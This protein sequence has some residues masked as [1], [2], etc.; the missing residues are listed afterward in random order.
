MKFKR[1]LIGLMAVSLVIYLVYVARIYERVSGIFVVFSTPE[2]WLYSTVAFGLILAGHWVRA[3][4]AKLLLRPVKDSGIRTQFQALLIGYLFNMLLP[5]RLGEIVRAIVLGR[6]LKISSSFMF[7]LIVL[8]RAFDGIIL[9][10][11]G[12]ALLLYPGLLPDEIRD[13]VALFSGLLLLVAALLITLLVLLYRQDAKLLRFWH[14]FTSIFNNQLKNSL[15]FKLWSVIYG[16]HKVINRRAIALY[17]IRSAAM[18]AAYLAA[19]MILASYFF[20][21]Q[22][23]NNFLQAFI[24]FLGV[25]IPSGP[26]YL[27]SY[28]AVADPLFQILAP[29]EGATHWLVASWMLLAIPSSILGAALLLRHRTDYGKLLASKGKDSLHDKLARI[30]DTSQEFT[31]FLDAY[32]SRN[33][34]SHVLHRLE[35]NEDIRLIR[36]FK[37]GS[38][39]VTLLAHQNQDYLVKKIVPIQYAHRLKAQYEWLKKHAHLEKIVSVTDE[40]EGKDFYY[41]DIEYHADLI[42]F[43]DYIHANSLDRSKEV[44]SGIFRYLFNY[45]YELEPKKRHIEDVETYIRN[46]VIQKLDDASHR[47]LELA[48]LRDYDKLI[49]N[50]VEY[51]NIHVVLNKI[52]HTPHIWKDITTYRQSPIHGDTQVD[53]ML[54]STT[55]HSF[56]IIDPVDQNEVSSPVVDFGRMFQSLNYGYEFLCR[57]DAPVIPDGNVISF[58]DSTSAAYR[59]LYDHCRLVAQDLLEPEEFRSVLFHTAVHYSR[60]STHRVQIN[61]RNVAKFYGTSVRAF[62]D[63]LAQYKD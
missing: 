49:I 20:P 13:A 5:L 14:R 9:G 16:L 36:Y 62:N 29:G 58:E 11:I 19:L 45:V 17:A 60:M 46:K 59:E 12:L 54:V 43:F 41:I 63:F 53:N 10:V 40:R 30:E 51:D 37:G 38:D 1:F 47:N 42:P 28:Q 44:L 61:P 4:K 7:A 35:I 48:R 24:S 25:S 2:F 21:Y 57:E 56:K 3:W 18:W 33:T 27:G 52:H 22:L 6:S 23:G 8:E 39:A 31:A 34:L 26:A 15:R 32:F 55:D 50:G